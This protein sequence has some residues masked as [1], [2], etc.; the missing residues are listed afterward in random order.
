M[1]LDPD[2][3]RSLCASPALQMAVFF[4][5]A[6]NLP[7]EE[8]TDHELLEI[9]RDF[10]PHS[11]RDHVKGTQKLGIMAERRKH[12]KRIQVQNSGHSCY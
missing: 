3:R 7:S 6:L 9:S 5:P 12:K 4:H 2:F 8:V 11:V 10:P 1:Y